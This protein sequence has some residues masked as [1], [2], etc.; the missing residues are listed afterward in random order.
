VNPALGDNPLKESLFKKTERPA[1]EP[2][3][4]TAIAR[5][6]GPDA[7]ATPASQHARYILAFRLG[8]R[9]F[10]ADISQVDTVT[11][12][13]F[14]SSV[15]MAPQFVDGIINVRGKV[16]PVISLTKLFGL[17]HTRPLLSRRMLIGRFGE[18]QIALIVDSVSGIMDMSREEI[19]PPS[20]SMP[21][22]SVCTGVAKLRQP[23]GELMMILDFG[24]LLSLEQKA[25]LEGGVELEEGSR[26]R[27]EAQMAEHII[28]QAA[29]EDTSTDILRR[30]AELLSLPVVSTERHMRRILTFAMAMEVYG[31]DIATVRK[32]LPVRK[33]AQL[34]CA[35]KYVRGVVNF[36][37]EITPVVDLKG[38]L[39]IAKSVT[40][41]SGGRLIVVEHEGTLTAFA[42]D[43]LF[44]VLEI[45]LE[46]VEAPLLTI[47]KLRA[48]FIDGEVQV[49][50][51]LVIILS[52]RNI[53]LSWETGKTADVG[54]QP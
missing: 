23:E 17:Q 18:E 15:P 1:P 22:A 53:M 28:P 37:G 6:A 47:E 54:A 11:R 13:I 2:E 5:F 7:S 39:G 41:P 35:P 49:G 40:Q 52:W 12:M 25:I 45:D 10:G 19:S 9:A 32:I 20:P 30:R 31:L 48:D 4:E 50:E 16:V 29:E 42:V 51:R 26:E 34:P 36:E 14:I 38:M 27:G 8:D 43:E 33:I 24:K 21:M 44:D 3:M 46:K